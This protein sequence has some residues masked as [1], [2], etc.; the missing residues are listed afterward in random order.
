MADIL[1]QGSLFHLR[2]ERVSYI[3]CI[4]PHG[5]AA[6]LYFGE[7]VEAIHPQ[8]LLRHFGVGAEADFTLQNCALDRVPQEYPSFGL[9][10]L[11]E[12][13]P[14]YWAVARNSLSW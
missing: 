14:F 9:G 3:F 8:N 10:D 11:R 4:L 2:N 13:S 1:W 5:I 6:H 12:G 7:R